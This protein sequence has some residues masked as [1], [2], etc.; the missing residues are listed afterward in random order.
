VANLGTVKRIDNFIRIAEKVADKRTR[1]IVIGAG[2]NREAL[3]DQA[4]Q[5]SLG[6]R[7]Q[8]IHTLDN[9]FD[10]MKL[11]DVGV[12]TSDAEG[13]SNTLIEYQMCGKPALA[14]DVGGNPEVI[15][16]GKT[17]F[18]IT[19][20]DLDGMAQKLNFLL[21]DENLRKSMGRNAS[22]WA[23]AE[24]HGSRLIRRTSD[25]YQHSLTGADIQD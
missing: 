12:L 1:F 14:F 6:D 3:L 5:L 4:R 11:F 16:N 21:T 22:S 10:Y 25:F 24:F 2:K 23:R 15:Q 8:I 17:G 13:L 18:L 19:P 20:G 9:V 7:L